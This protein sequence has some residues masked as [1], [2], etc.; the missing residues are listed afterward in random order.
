MQDLKVKV[1]EHEYGSIYKNIGT[2]CQAK[3]LSKLTQKS[4]IDQTICNKASPSY[5]N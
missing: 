3:K 1:P 4:R 2:T 5:K